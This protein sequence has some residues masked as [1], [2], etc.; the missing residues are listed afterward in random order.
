MKD[1]VKKQTKAILKKSEEERERK[2]QK[3]IENIIKLK[4]Y[5]F[6]GMFNF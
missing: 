6:A 2:E 5:D 3:R 4:P 1:A